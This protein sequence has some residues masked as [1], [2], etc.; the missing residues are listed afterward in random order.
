VNEKLFDFIKAVHER[1]KT[2]FDIRE[3]KLIY[4]EGVD[5]EFIEV[6]IQTEH[7]WCKVT[8]ALIDDLDLEDLINFTESRLKTAFYMFTPENPP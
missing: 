1:L 6:R 7:Y 8:D 2:T 4:R 3:V 5:G